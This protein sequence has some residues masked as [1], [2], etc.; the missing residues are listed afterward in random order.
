[1]DSEGTNG[2]HIVMGFCDVYRVIHSEVKLFMITEGVF[3]CVGD[4]HIEV[5]YGMEL[6]DLL[7]CGTEGRYVNGGMDTGLEIAG[8]GQRWLDLKLRMKPWLVERLLE[9]MVSTCSVSN[10]RVLLQMADGKSEGEPADGSSVDGGS[11]HE[12]LDLVSWRQQ[13]VSYTW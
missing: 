10:T 11:G 8:T 1:M 13:R 3:L 6:N 12:Y 5:L 4:V 7:H 2:E 9:T